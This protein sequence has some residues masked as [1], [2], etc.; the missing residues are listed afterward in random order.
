MRL[1]HA[2]TYAKRAIGVDIQ[3]RIDAD[4]I[5][6]Y[7]MSSND[8]FA[9]ACSGDIDLPEVDMFFID[10]DHSYEQSL[11]DVCNA[12]KHV[13][14]D[15]L[16]LLHDTFPETEEDKSL[17]YCGEVYRTAK[18]IRENMLSMCEIVTLPSYAGMSIIRKLR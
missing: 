13:R 17:K 18:Y 9:K 3:Q 15:G 14:V 10:G 16:I 5:E 2:K 7:N 12:L 1:L 4:N 6:F 11:Q 8:F